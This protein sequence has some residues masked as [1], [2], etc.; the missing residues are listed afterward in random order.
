MAAKQQ[1]Q[2]PPF[3]ERESCAGTMLSMILVS[4]EVG[5]IIVRLLQRRTVRLRKIKPL[6]EGHAAREQGG[7]AV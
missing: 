4:P 1:Q 5:A 3:T 6:V 2:Q 7:W